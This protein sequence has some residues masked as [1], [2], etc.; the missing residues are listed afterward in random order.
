MNNREWG[1]W[2]MQ[3][4]RTWDDLS[5]VIRVCGLDSVD[6][7][8]RRMIEYAL[9][10]NSLIETMK[11]P[12]LSMETI[13][14]EGRFLIDFFDYTAGHFRREEEILARYGLPRLESHKIQHKEILSMMEGVIRQF[15]SGQINVTKSLKVSVMDWV[16]SHINEVDYETFKVENWAWLL[17]SAKSWDDLSVFIRQMGVDDIDKQHRNLTVNSLELCHILEN[18][19]GQNMSSE[20]VLPF[21]EDFK[22][23]IAGHFTY[24]EAF[25][26]R[27]GI[28]GL[29]DHRGR[30]RGFIHQFE[31]FE[32]EL[33]NAGS[34]DASK[35]AR[36]ILSWWVNHINDTDYATFC[37]NAWQYS[38]LERAQTLDQVAGIVRSTGVPEFDH[39][40]RQ[41]VE[42]TVS[43]GDFRETPGEVLGILEKLQ[44]AAKSHF[45][46]EEGFLERAG[47]PGLAN[48]RVEHA[49]LVVALQDHVAHYRAGRIGEIDDLRVRML[50]WIVSHTNGYD[51]DT[52]VRSGF[53]KSENAG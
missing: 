31:T 26:A 20:S 8:H 6:D 33:R 3:T 5:P 13:K 25:M 7:D 30:H 52:F 4:A 24:E 12:R 34:L 29:A 10:V 38:S 9:E 40:H 27:Q 32:S 23:Q 16:V 11:Q 49:R 46:H 17:E 22:T 18:A 47:Y 28:E 48:H 15:D 36:S 2:V 50:D 39:E 42:L 1:R 14:R 37:K 41:L 51:Y 35:F 21:F 53:F 43:L 44:V 19:Q 45:A